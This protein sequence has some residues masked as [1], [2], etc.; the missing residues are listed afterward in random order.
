MKSLL[1]RNDC[2]L[3]FYNS[4]ISGRGEQESGVK[5]LLL[6]FIKALQF[7]DVPFHLS[8]IAVHLRECHEIRIQHPSKNGDDDNHA[9]YAR[10]RVVTLFVFVS[11]FVPYC[12]I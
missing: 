11:H 4:S 8:N 9:C 2:S 12:L 1:F 5:H 3:L 6:V 7:T 10:E